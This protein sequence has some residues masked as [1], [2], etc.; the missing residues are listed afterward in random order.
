[1][2]K[3]EIIWWVLA[4]V[5][6]G[7]SESK[8]VWV[9]FAGVHETSLAGVDFQN[10]FA[11]IGRKERLDG[12]PFLT[13]NPICLCESTLADDVARFEEIT[14]V[15]TEECLRLDSRNTFNIIWYRDLNLHK[16]ERVDAG[17]RGV[18]IEELKVVLEVWRERCRKSYE[19]IVTDRRTDMLLFGQEWDMSVA[20][21]HRPSKKI[22]AFG[23]LG[24]SRRIKRST[25]VARAGQRAVHYPPFT[26]NQNS[27]PP[28]I[29]SGEIVEIE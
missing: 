13:I 24:A 17:S 27:V 7:K 4:C 10:T 12:E 5:N 25:R 8:R 14:I 28:V 11:F 19:N 22:P 9:V 6:D 15:V 26:I 16:L 23:H 2:S 21:F 3:K 29:W 20:Y 18:V 1:M